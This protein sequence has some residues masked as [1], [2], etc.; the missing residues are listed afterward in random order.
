L[1]AC[2]YSAEHRKR[3]SPSTQRRAVRHGSRV[4]RTSAPFNSLFNR[5]CV[6]TW[7]P[8]RTSP[9]WIGPNLSMTNCKFAATTIYDSLRARP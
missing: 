6:P 8:A 3:L 1:A 4:F 5:D 7:M 2:L 9:R